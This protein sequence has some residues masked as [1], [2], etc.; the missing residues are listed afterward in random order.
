M[1]K[2][3]NNEG[4]YDALS[5]KIDSII[6]NSDFNGVVAIA[7]NDKIK[8]SNAVG[9]SNLE[10]ETKLHLNDQFVIGSI[11]K[12]ITAVLILREYEKGTIQLE[13]KIEQYLKEIEQPWAKD[14]SIHH[15]LTHTHGI[16]ELNQALAF[17]VGTKFQYSQL[18]YELLA[19]ILES[20]TNKSFQELS[21]EL[22]ELFDLNNS[23]HPKSKGYKKL[24][25]GYVEEENGRLVFSENSLYNYPAAG[26]FIS[27]A[28]DLIKWN[29]LL[30]SKQLLNKETLALMKT[31]YAT[32]NHPIF[33]T[34]VYG[35]GLL[36]KK[37]ESNSQIGALGYTPGF[38]SAA[39]YYPKS[40]L[41]L[42][43]LQNT[44]RNLDDF[45]QT[46]KVPLK[47]MD[48]IKKM[49]SQSSR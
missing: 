8:Y 22:F 3:K 44:A 25:N 20:V 5:T 18:G 39:Y 32:R 35:Y 6:S 49:N 24:V 1:S 46:F 47:L 43:V 12:Q 33:E 13:D 19:Q 17:E 11:S 15:L 7:E 9:F 41:N 31:N 34:I 40:K 38:V 23:F 14:V 10:N 16:E 2:E 4:K 45:K 37:G 27:N 36:F 48:E 30:H 29:Y 21:K 26:S 28:E 42:I